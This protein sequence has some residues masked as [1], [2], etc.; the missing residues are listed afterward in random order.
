MTFI[1]VQAIVTV[2]MLV[3]PSKGNP[4]M[5]IDELFSIPYLI[6]TIVIL[7]YVVLSK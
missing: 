1:V 4:P 3:F 6:S 7:I 5:T 2:L